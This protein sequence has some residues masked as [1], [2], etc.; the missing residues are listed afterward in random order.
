MA[1]YPKRVWTWKKLVYSD[2]K[3]VWEL[4][5]KVWV[6]NPNFTEVSE[7]E[8]YTDRWQ[9]VEATDELVVYDCSSKSEYVWTFEDGTEATYTFEDYDETVLKTGKVKDGK[10]PVAPTDPTREWYTFTWWDPEVGPIS[11]DTIYTA[12]Y[13]INV[14]Y[15]FQDY[16]ETVISSG[17]VMSGTAPTPPEDPTREGYTFTWWS[18]EVWAIT[19]DTTY[20]ATYEENAADPVDL[21]NEALNSEGE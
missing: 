2:K 9:D 4:D 12:T 14:A 3:P 15:T 17:T 18:P 8:T 21:L 20:T 6:Y 16:D 7:W 13:T 10:T 11:K 5:W 1:T 19:E